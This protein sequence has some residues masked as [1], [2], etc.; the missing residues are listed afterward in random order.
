LEQ[1]KGNRMTQKL[2]SSIFFVLMFVSMN[3]FGAHFENLIELTIKVE[4]A[5]YSHRVKTLHFNGEEI[6][7][8]PS[9]M[10]K[11]RKIL[12]YKLPPG[13]YTLIW[14]TEKTPIRWSEDSIK[15]FEKILVLEHGDGVVKINLKGE[16]VSLY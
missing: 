13:R 1:T 2:L 9:D 11:P 5:S 14:T 7:L 15:R 10:F 8:D 3:A 12:Q 6:K 4:D 16:N